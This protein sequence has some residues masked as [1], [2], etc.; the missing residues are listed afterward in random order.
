MEVYAIAVMGLAKLRIHPEPGSQATL[1]ARGIYRWI[2]HPMYSGLLLAT[3]CLA[4]G[5]TPGWLG[6]ILWTCLLVD[7]ILKAK[8]E[9]QLLSEQMPGYADYMKRTKRLIPGI[10]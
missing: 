6:A 8:L 1:C 3:G 10:Y 9:E 5:I 7:L 2:R 4:F